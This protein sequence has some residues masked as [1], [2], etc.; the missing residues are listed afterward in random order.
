MPRSPRR[1]SRSR[2]RS[3]GRKRHSRRSRSRSPRDR[4]NSRSPR[5]SSP[6]RSPPLRRDRDRSPRRLRRDRSHSR[7]RSRSRSRDR[8][9]IDVVVK[10]L[11]TLYLCMIVSRR[12]YIKVVSYVDDLFHFLRFGRLISRRN[13]RE[14]ERRAEEDQKRKK[15]DEERRLEEDRIRRRLPIILVVQDSPSQCTYFVHLHCPKML[16]RF[17]IKLIR[18][19]YH[20]NISTYEITG[21]VCTIVPQV[22][23]TY[24]NT[25]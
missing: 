25:S 3:P 13:D 20:I 17:S 9:L 4:R 1:S 7:S 5:R 21:F 18:T 12:T 6:R 16:K 8:Y 23:N 24:L 11:T 15:E 2:S 22:P 14:R 19:Y 10:L